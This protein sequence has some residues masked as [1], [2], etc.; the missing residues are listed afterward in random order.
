[1]RIIPCPEP[2]IYEDVPMGDYLAWDAASNTGIG[3]IL[4][5]PAHLVAYREGEDK[6]TKDLLIGRAAHTAVFEADKFGD[7]FYEIP[8]ADPEIFRNKDGSESKVPAN[9]AGYKAAKAKLAEANPDKVG[10]PAEDWKGNKR[11]LEAVLGHSR[12]AKI[13]QSTGRA[14]LSVVFIDPATGVLCKIRIDWHTPTTSGGAINDLKTTQDASPGEFERSIFRWGYHRQGALYLRGAKIAG[15]PVE[16]FTLT[17]VE[18]KKP[19]GVILYRLLE[20]A[21]R[22]GE[23]QIDMGLQLYA[24]CQASGEWPGYTTDVVDIGVPKWADAAV[25]RSLEDVVI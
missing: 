22:L 3:K 17:A 16:H 12:V 20:E 6:D 11:I 25:E 2:G 7:T 24:H 10:L 9:T 5:S 18:K 8:W 15:L 1:M 13:I 19:H 23:V 4:K 21:V 14:E